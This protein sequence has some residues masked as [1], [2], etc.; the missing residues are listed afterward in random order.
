MMIP[1][2]SFA[3]LASVCSVSTGVLGM[4]VNTESPDLS[5]LSSQ[6]PSFNAVYTLDEAQMEDDFQ[7]LMKQVG[8]DEL[9]ADLPSPS[10]VNQV[11]SSETKN[12]ISRVSYTSPINSSPPISTTPEPSLAMQ[13]L[14]SQYGPFYSS[15]EQDQKPAPKSPRQYSQRVR[16]LMGSSNSAEKSKST[17][18]KNR[19][20]PFLGFPDIALDYYLKKDS[21]PYRTKNEMN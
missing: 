1:S 2:L 8:Y 21:F 10:P 3:L 17:S 20:P 7:A 12:Q 4:P 5:P 9:M 11:Q 19:D 13:S 6:A 18:F 16:Q 14:F 15:F